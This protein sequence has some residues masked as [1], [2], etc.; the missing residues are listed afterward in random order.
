MKKMMVSDKRGSKDVNKGIS[1]D[2]I[3][4]KITSEMKGKLSKQYNRIR[5][6]VKKEG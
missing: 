1:P 4:D 2:E 6:M 3:P 5:T